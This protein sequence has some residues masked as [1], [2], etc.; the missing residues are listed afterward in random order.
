MLLKWLFCQ[1]IKKLCHLE[2]LLK[3][4]Y[5]RSWNASKAF[6]LSKIATMVKKN[7][8][9]LQASFSSKAIWHLTKN[10]LVHCKW[11]GRNARP[12]VQ[13]HSRCPRLRDHMQTLA[14]TLT[15][16]IFLSWC[17]PI[18][19]WLLPSPRELVLL[20]SWNWFPKKWCTFTDLLGLYAAAF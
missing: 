4:F 2:I 19:T 13:C 14:R 16:I 15:L 17:V 18:I 1:K 8:F 10:D 11:L 20:Q 7:I 6:C 12:M 9:L 3:A 5:K